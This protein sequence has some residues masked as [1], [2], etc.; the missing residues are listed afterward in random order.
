MADGRETTAPGQL[1]LVPAFL[2][3]YDRQAGR[4]DLADV[5]SAAAWLAAAR[6]VSPGT[7]FD[8]RDRRRLV[9]VRG[10]VLFLV[11]SNGGAD[12][13]PA[14]LHNLRASSDVELQVGRERQNCRAAVIEPSDPGYE[15]LWKIVNENNRDRYSAYQE[16]TIRPIPVV[17]LTPA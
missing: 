16:Q 17:V 4:D 3:T 10:A 8:E 6:L 5:S 1:G 2:N 13:H 9:E 11:A 7:E 12:R 14:W 15:R